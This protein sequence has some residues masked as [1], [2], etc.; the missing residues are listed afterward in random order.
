MNEQDLDSSEPPSGKS[1]FL[2]NCKLGFDSESGQTNDLKIGIHSFPAGRSATG[3]NVENKPASLL[4][5]LGKAISKIPPSWCGRQIAGNS[6]G[7]IIVL[8]FVA[9]ITLSRE[10]NQCAIRARL[11]VASHLSTTPRLGNP[12]K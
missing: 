2:W 6:Y 11:G 5:L 9:F 7:R 4:V 8:C 3:N 10:S 1:V 12:V